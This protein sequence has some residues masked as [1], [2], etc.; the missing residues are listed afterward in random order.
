MH[1]KPISMDLNCRDIESEKDTDTVGY[2]VMQKDF[3]NE[4]HAA[5]YLGQLS[6]SG[7][8]SNYITHLAISGSQSQLA[9]VCSD[10]SLS[11][12]DWGTLKK[13][14]SMR[15]H[16]D[17]VTGVRYVPGSDSVLVS[18]SLDGTVR[19]WDT[20]SGQMTMEHSDTTLQKRKP[21]TCVDV[22]AAGRFLCAGT[23]VVDQDAYLVFWDVRQPMPLG[24][25]WESHTD[26][27]STV[28]F[29]PTD[30]GA[31]ATGSTDG[32]VNVFDVT[33]TSED[34][35]LQATLNTESSVSSVTWYERSDGRHLAVV[36]DT[37]ELQLWDLQESERT[38]QFGRQEV[39]QAIRRTMSEVCYV[40]S[41]HQTAEGD[42]LAV[43]GATTK[44]GHG[45]LRLLRI[46]GD[47]LTPHALLEDSEVTQQLVRASAFSPATGELVTGGEGGMLTLWRPGAR[48][49]SSQRR[50]AKAPTHKQRGKH[51]QKPY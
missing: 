33:Q 41:C 15:G 18:S 49:S 51:K 25:Y 47:R 21:L 32:Y 5:A 50:D 11:L 12:F 34:D 4:Y 1:R 28:R 43:A 26:E 48:P 24:G 45:C 23:E 27:L 16:T 22:N 6:D 39:A 42:V 37:E 9:A 29:H 35:A 31:L 46:D 13:L 30:S 2:D 19:Q 3:P 14:H 20:R 44:E 38:A 8:K 10:F 40:E 17:K 7:K 36:L